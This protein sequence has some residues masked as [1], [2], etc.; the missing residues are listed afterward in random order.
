[1]LNGIMEHVF[2]WKLKNNLE[3]GSNYVTQSGFKLVIRHPRIVSMGESHFEQV[4]QVFSESILWAES[5]RMSSP[6]PPR[7]PLP[8]RCLSLPESTIDHML[9]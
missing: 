1:M 4:M 6:P 8:P 9:L 7:I 2:K 5:E 3:T